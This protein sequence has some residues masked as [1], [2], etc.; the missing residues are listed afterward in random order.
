MGHALPRPLQ[1][2]QHDELPW[3]ATSNALSLCLT[4]KDTPHAGPVALGNAIGDWALKFQCIRGCA[5][6]ELALDLL[7]ADRPALVIAF[8]LSIAK[9]APERRVVV[10]KIR[11]QCPSRMGRP[12]SS[13][14]PI[15]S[16][17][18]KIA[19]AHAIANLSSL[20]QFHRCPTGR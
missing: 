2:L 18:P 7:T 3:N 17:Q 19:H 5:R 15:I 9:M 16:E 12:S 8:Q 6:I 14:L 4:W 13:S 20:T 1:S 11:S 10:Q